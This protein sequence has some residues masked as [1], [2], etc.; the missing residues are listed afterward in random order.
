VNW[1]GDAGTAY[2]AAY[3][4]GFA[5]ETGI[6]VLQDGSGPTEGAIAAQFE[7]GAPAGTSSMPTRSR[8]RRWAS[9]A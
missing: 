3:G 5:A 9:R 7:S 2:D 4:Q 6:S 8:P 1:G